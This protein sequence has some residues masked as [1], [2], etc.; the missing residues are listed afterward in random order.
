MRVVPSLWAFFAHFATSE[1][2]KRV[3]SRSGQAR[4]PWTGRR[5]VV[6]EMAVKNG[7]KHERLVEKGGNALLVGLDADN[8]VLGE[9]AG[10]VGEEADR[11]EEVLDEDGLEDVEL[12]EMEKREE[13]ER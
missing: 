1:A 10:A 8:A 2:S 6:A 5:T 4:G 12:S 13:R 3:S 11:L 7:G 9:G